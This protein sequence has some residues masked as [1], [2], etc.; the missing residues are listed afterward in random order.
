MYKCSDG[1]IYQGWW[2][3]NK[4]HGLG[5][6]IRSP[7]QEPEFGLWQMSR[8]LQWFDK[9][10]IKAIESHQFYYCNLF[11]ALKSKDPSDQD[12]SFEEI[13]EKYATIERYRSRF[14]KKDGSSLGFK[15]PVHL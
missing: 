3:N 1:S 8:H 12:L 4:Q 15:C 14:L 6:F 7:N 10:T 9:E 2:S 11:S 5:I 13:E